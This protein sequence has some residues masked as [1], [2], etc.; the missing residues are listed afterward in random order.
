M[1]DAYQ[2]TVHSTPLLLL[3][4]AM[5]ALGV[6]VLLR[7]RSAL[8]ARLFAIL[9]W[10]VA[11]WLGCF[12]MM[13]AARFAP[14]A[15][16]WGRGGMIFI[17]L[18]A[19]AVYHFTVVL[20]R[21]SQRRRL[22]IVNAWVV[23]AGFATLIAPTDLVI[24]SVQRWSWGFYPK[25]GV[26][27]SFFILFVATVLA[28]A[29]LELISERRRTVPQ[30]RRDKLLT[31]I[32]SYLLAYTALV[33]VLPMFG[34]GVYPFGFVFI[35]L[36]LMQAARSIAEYRLVGI[37]TSVAAREI[38]ET[39]ADALIV[40]DGEGRIQVVNHAVE[41][42]FGFKEEELIGRSIEAFVTDTNATLINV[43]RLRRALG[44]GTLRDL[45][46]VFRTKSGEAVEVSISISPLRKG[47]AHVG[48]VLI[49]RD[50]R[51]RKENERQI[52]HAAS[53]LQSTLESTADGILVIDRER[54]IVSYNQR[55]ASMFRVS[56]TVLER[57][58]D[59]RLIEG[60]VKQLKDPEVF[61]NTIQR[62][63]ASPEA[64][65]FDILEFSDGRVF[66][67][68]SIPQKLDGMTVGRVWSFRDVTERRKAE[69]ALRAS[70]KRYRTLFERNL[71]G[72]YRN[73]MDGTILD[74]NEAFARTFGFD[75]RFEMIGRNA[76]ELFFHASE[77]QAILDLLQKVK[78]LSGLELCLKR[79][80][81][82]RV[83]V[84]ENVSLVEGNGDPA[85]ME[86]TLVDISGLKIAEEQMEFQAYHDV[87]TCL[88]NRKLFIDR[89]TLA[90]AQAK[91]TGSMLAVMFLDID[92]FKVIND[93]LGHTIGDE[94][95]LT[96]AERLSRT[97]REGDTVARLG[98]DEFT[99]LVSSLHDP[100][101]AAKI[102]EQLLEAIEEPVTVGNRQLYVTASIGIALSPDDGTDAESLLK[103]A[104]SALYR[105]KDAGRNNY[106]L[107]TEEMK[108]RALE[109]LSL[110]NSLRRALDRG[111]LLL[112]YQPVVSL[113]TGRITGM[114][115]LLRWAH[116]ER[117]M[118]YPEAFIP[119]A[120]SSRLIVPIGEW[121]LR[122]ACKQ[123]KLWQD[124]GYE[125][126]RMSVNLSARQF[127]QRDLA[128]SIEAVLRESGLSPDKLE[129]EITETTAMANADVT[130]ETLQNLKGMGVAISIDDFGTGYSS[131]N[132]LKRFPINTVKIDKSFVRDLH[133][134]ASDAAI[135]TAVIGIARIL[136][137]R[138]IAE[139]VETE[140]QLAFLRRKECEEMQGYFFGGPMPAD[141]LTI[142]LRDRNG[143]IEK[144]ESRYLTN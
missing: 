86:G 48:S 13:H 63:D 70:E 11:G 45:E 106:Q 12:A 81:G 59:A 88:P 94:L 64:E 10:T 72:V 114:E 97:I 108:I 77:R 55:F 20:L 91:R 51:P 4:V 143:A 101:D 129:L 54:H 92:H 43:D 61:L 126:F 8:P 42:L 125:S 62:L 56:P 65:S 80:D 69:A 15:M 83:W 37:N 133:T 123:A 30:G 14:S 112:H 87:L 128:Q 60:I 76:A 100:D 96:V 44:Q 84:L 142:V 141:E 41:S 79:R 35:L 29:V 131:L 93:T 68:H 98:G 124:L 99:I 52:K 122:T 28:G 115:A 132:Y 3:S 19:P 58:D 109:R 34:I 117:G 120:E 53:L 2:M 113:S 66:E 1:S 110:E 102:A 135:I 25:F 21:I 136:K 85:V 107:C 26:M 7:Q 24:A 90:L 140:E 49:A 39:M 67:R 89:L 73:A 57:G 118:T 71:A 130:I 137:L 104:D 18:L 47:E 36:F 40:C 23:G 22:A 6:I 139:G 32:V 78:N 134:D 17:A 121:V 33:D 16:G 50:I 74:C 9:A 27:G 38:V 103:N 111:E 46:K 144:A 116:P 82:S 75:S 31:L 138:V 5:L 105:A 119:L 95:L 127:Q